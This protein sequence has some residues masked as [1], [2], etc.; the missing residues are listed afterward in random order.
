MNRKLMTLTITAA[1]L[2]TTASPALALQEDC[3]DIQAMDIHHS[4]EKANPSSTEEKPSSELKLTK[5]Q[6]QQRDALL[7]EIKDIRELVRGKQQEIG[8]LRRE[9]RQKLDG[10]STQGKKLTDEQYTNIKGHL[11]NISSIQ[12]EI[13][14]ERLEISRNHHNNDNK[15]FDM[16]VK[17]LEETKGLEQKRMEKLEE[18]HKSLNEVKKIIG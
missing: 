10:L 14:K 7:K 1:L 18:I 15:S 17:E 2:L 13:D 8:N 5:E 4:L 11:D 12:Q 16:L 6:V 9:I 3:W